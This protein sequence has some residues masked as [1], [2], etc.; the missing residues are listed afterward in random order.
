[1]KP[2]RMTTL[3]SAILIACSGCTYVKTDSLTILDFH[4]VGGNTNIDATKTPE[5]MTLKASR[6]QGSAEGIVDAVTSAVAV[7]PLD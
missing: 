2:L 5:G 7:S 1:M 6:G 4:P 3:T